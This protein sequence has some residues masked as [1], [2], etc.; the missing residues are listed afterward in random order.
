MVEHSIHLISTSKKTVCGNG[1]CLNMHSSILIAGF[2]MH[3][4]SFL[5]AMAKKQL[6]ASRA[7][8]EGPKKGTNQGENTKKVRLRTEQPQC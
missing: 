2:I 3:T 8:C 6:Y 4:V 5:S 1:R 7:G